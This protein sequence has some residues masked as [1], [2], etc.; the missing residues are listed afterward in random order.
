MFLFLTFRQGE[1]GTL[2]QYYI[3]PVG[4]SGCTDNRNIPLTHQ[5]YC[6]PYWNDNIDHI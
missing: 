5:A 3:S 2:V 1:L 4:D 6:F